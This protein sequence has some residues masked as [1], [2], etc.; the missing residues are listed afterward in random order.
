MKTALLER[1]R[2]LG[3]RI[4]NFHGWQMPLFYS[5]IRNEHNVVRSSAGVFDVSHMFRI[6]ITGPDAV[7][8]VDHV[9]TAAFKSVPSGKCKYSFVLTEKGAVIDDV[10]VYKGGD[11]VLIVSNASNGRKVVAHLARNKG[12]FNVKISNESS[13]TG[14]IAVQGPT[15]GGFARSEFG[16]A[17]DSLK[18]YEFT[19]ITK[20]S[21]KIFLSRTGYTGEDGFEVIA[22]AE[23]TS[24]LWD[25][26]IAAGAKPCGLAARDSLRL[27]AG[28][29]LYG[30]ELSEKISV[31]DSGLNFAIDL[32]KKSFIGM[33][34]M[35]GNRK[36]RL[37]GF[38]MNS[39]RIARHGYEVLCDGKKAGIVTSGTY[40]FTLERSIGMAYVGYKFKDGQFVVKIR[41]SF[42]KITLV[43]LPFYRRG[44]IFVK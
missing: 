28:M 6:V 22:D 32:T 34:K 35:K 3:A 44:K 9:L 10:V 7:D 30:N 39:P 33:K 42:E 17:F 20:D 18:Y 40:S 2:K 4:T 15:A 1:H 41:D 11:F 19:V 27:E 23:Y 26:F 38:L 21:N 36:N 37:V 29:P 13:K 5:G 43:P 14:M 24:L 31:L 25:N 16:N 8:F 12:K